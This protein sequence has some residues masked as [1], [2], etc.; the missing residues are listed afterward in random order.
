MHGKQLGFSE[1]IQHLPVLWLNRKLLQVKVTL[2]GCFPDDF[3]H[4]TE[5]REEFTTHGAVLIS[6]SGSNWLQFV[7]TVRAKINSER[8]RQL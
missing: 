1:T 5:S 3:C 6:F 8:F 4:V 7:I 2:R